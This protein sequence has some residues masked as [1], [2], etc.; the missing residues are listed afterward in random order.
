M[1]RR[2]HEPFV[3]TS[4]MSGHY[5]MHGG[6][7]PL[8]GSGHPVALIKNRRSGDQHVGSGGHDQWRC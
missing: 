8:H 6:S 4:F 7:Q 5:L 2:L 3:L 1:F